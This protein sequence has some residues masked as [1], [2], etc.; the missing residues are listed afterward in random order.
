MSDSD[1]R[2][3]RLPGRVALVDFYQPVMSG[4]TRPEGW[5]DMFVYSLGLPEYPCKPPPHEAGE[6]A[7]E[8]HKFFF[9]GYGTR[10]E[11]YP[12]LIALRPEPLF[13]IL[14]DIREVR[15][16]DEEHDVSS[17]F[18]R[19]T[20]AKVFH[21]LSRAVLVSGDS[22]GYCPTVDPFD[23]NWNRV[24]YDE[25]LLCHH[26]YRALIHRDRY[27]FLKALGIRIPERLTAT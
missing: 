17:K 20:P 8:A 4:K 6:A 1:D 16:I 22:R 26:A 27:A 23:V 2:G 10:H 9:P 13:M 19:L 7:I 11:P 5:E 3:R 25:K 18:V 15:G 14:H 24:H 21:D 12:H